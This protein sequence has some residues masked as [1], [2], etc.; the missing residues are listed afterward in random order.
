MFTDLDMPRMGGLEL[1]FDLRQGR[2]KEQRVVVV[3][4]RSAE[5]FRPR[6]LE[7]GASAYLSKPVADQELKQLLHELELVE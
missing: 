5:E 7:L 6:A 2:H 1:L 4:S 3:S